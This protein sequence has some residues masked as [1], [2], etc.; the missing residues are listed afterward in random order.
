VVGVVIVQPKEDLEVL[1]VEVQVLEAE[2]LAL[3]LGKVLLA[4]MD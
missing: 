1:A 4:V 2:V 3:F